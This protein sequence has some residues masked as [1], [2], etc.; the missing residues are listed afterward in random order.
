M[1]TGTSQNAQCL[2]AP[3]SKFST[4]F[5]TTANEHHQENRQLRFYKDIL[6]AGNCHKICKKK[7][8]IKKINR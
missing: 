1:K 8:I 5:K 3:L 6:F 2:Q 7:L 4:K